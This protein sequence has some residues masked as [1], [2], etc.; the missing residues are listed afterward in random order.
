MDCGRVS[1]VSAPP[2]SSPLQWTLVLLESSYCV[3]TD[4][5]TWVA[6]RGTFLSSSTVTR[7]LPVVRGFGNVQCTESRVG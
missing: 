2:F 3:I 5:H 1:L 7:R 6:R 4:G